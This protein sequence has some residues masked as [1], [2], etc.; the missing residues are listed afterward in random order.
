[1]MQR[2]RRQRKL[3]SAANSMLKNGERNVNRDANKVASED[4]T[5]DATKDANEEDDYVDHHGDIA[6]VGN[7]LTALYTIDKEEKEI[8]GMT[9][10]ADSDRR[11]NRRGLSSGS[12]VEAAASSLGLKVL[13]GHINIDIVVDTEVDIG[14][15]EAMKILSELEAIGFILNGKFRRNLSGSIPLDQIKNLA[16]MEHIKLARP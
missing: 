10:S 9:N 2:H 13:E 15:K 6:K 14:D 5:K 1:M 16:L 8:R 11:W 12:L 4:A 3:A 7:A